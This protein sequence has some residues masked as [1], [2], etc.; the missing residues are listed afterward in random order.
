M[1]T[2]RSYDTV[3]QVSGLTI[4]YQNIPGILVSE[5][6]HTEHELIIPLNGPLDLLVGDTSIRVPRG[7]KIFLPAG[8]KHSVTSPDADSDERLVVLVPLQLL[9]TKP[10]VPLRTTVLPSQNLV[11]EMLFFL[12]SETRNPASDSV[13]K[14]LCAVIGASLCAAN[15]P[16]DPS[17]AAKLSPLSEVQDPR[18]RKVMSILSSEFSAEIKVEDLAKQ[19]GVSQRTLNRLLEKE[20]GMG[21]VKLLSKIRIEEACRLLRETEFKVIDVAYESGF[22]S[23]SR[24]IEVFRQT[25]GMLPMEYRRVSKRDSV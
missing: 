15:D 14:A 22:G 8:T 25:T 4:I 24:F 7:Q 9:S 5:H 18:I 17:I 21:P 19:V 12:F 20:L 3:A 6:D 10:N 13:S 1:K 11:I 2:K 23:L 16:Q